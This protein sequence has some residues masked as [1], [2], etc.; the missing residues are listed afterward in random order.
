MT[1]RLLSDASL[2]RIYTLRRARVIWLRI[3]DADAAPGIKL[4]AAG[5]RLLGRVEAETRA[6][7]ER[8]AVPR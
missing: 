7:L 3:C 2:Q 8:M 4:N 5:A 1:A 6:M